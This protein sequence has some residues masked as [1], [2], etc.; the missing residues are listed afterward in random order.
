LVDNWSTTGRQLVDYSA[1]AF[2]ALCHLRVP[3]RQLVDNWLTTG[4]LPTQHW[5]YRPTGRWSPSKWSRTT[6][7]GRCFLPCHP[8]ARRS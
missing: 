8:S 1:S 6:R 7:F 2:I 5:L 4:R 3:G